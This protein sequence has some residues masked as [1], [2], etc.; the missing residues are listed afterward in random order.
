MKLRELVISMAM[1][2][3]TF[4][5]AKA[6][7]PPVPVPSP[8]IDGDEILRTAY[9]DTLSILSTSNEC[10]DFFGGSAASVEIFNGLIGK[11]RKDYFSPSIGIRMSGSAVNVFNVGKNRKYRLFNK[12]SI[13]GNGPFYRKKHSVSQ[14]FVPG[15][16]SFEA[17]TKE[18]RVLMFLHELGHIVKGQS[19]D[20]LLPDDGRDEVL[21]KDNTRKIED[22][23]GGQ[24][25]N[26][27][28]GDNAMNSAAGKQRDVKR[29]MANAEP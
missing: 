24:I 8:L 5:S 6:I 12:V 28:K 9:Y 16:G 21:S 4:L 10:S 7:T 18:V 2:S 14:P 20:W 1:M 17:N 3:L 23:C 15:V 27:G 25:R 11:V 19:G 22:V 13:N 26:L 29:P